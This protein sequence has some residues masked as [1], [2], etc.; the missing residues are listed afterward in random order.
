MYFAG[1]HSASAVGSEFGFPASSANFR[2]HAPSHMSGSTLCSNFDSSKPQPFL[3]KMYTP[4]DAQ[5]LPADIIVALTKAQLYLNPIHH[6]LQHKYA[7]LCKTLTKYVGR[8]LQV[9]ES[10]AVQRHVIP[11]IYQGA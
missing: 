6:Q 4:A 9:A 10:H 8:E 3:H 7:E 2:S 1:H 5:I 11:D